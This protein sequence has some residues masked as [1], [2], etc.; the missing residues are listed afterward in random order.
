MSTDSSLASSVRALLP[1]AD[2]NHPLEAIFLG[3]KHA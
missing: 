3:E 1:K 2:V